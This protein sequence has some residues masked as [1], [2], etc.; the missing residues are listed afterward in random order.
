[1]AHEDLTGTCHCLDTTLPE[2][3]LLL[4][5]ESDFA[6]ESHTLSP[7]L[8]IALHVSCHDEAQLI[9]PAAYLFITMTI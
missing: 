4:A 7:S 2:I 3:C 6:D 8:R 1:M 5:D 9:V